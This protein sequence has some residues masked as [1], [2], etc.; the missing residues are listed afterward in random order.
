MEDLIRKA[1]KGDANS[2]IKLF[3]IYEEQIYRTA[4]VYL[5]NKEDTLDVLQEVAA[6]SFQN[7]K[8]LKDPNS[9]K[10]WLL[11]I[12]YHSA[13]DFIRKRN[14]VKLFDKNQ[15]NLSVEPED[16]ALQVFLKDLIEN[17]EP[18]KRI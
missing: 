14:K 8:S 3:Q 2:Y 9:F 12:T 5:K 15:E 7:I 13:I 17:L 1:K 16:V 4:F 6:K 11:K 18:K 10:S